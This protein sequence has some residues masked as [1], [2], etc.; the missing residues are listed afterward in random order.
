MKG[1][2]EQYTEEM[3][4]NFGYYA[5]WE[6]GR[7]L[8][9][10]DIGTIKNNVFTRLSDLGSKGIA[11]E[12]NPDETAND[13]EYNSKG[14]VSVTTKLS[15]TVA[16]VGSSLTNVDAGIIVEFSKENSTLFKANK[17]RTPSIKDITALGAEILKRY[18]EGK[19]NKYWVIITE[20]V[21]AESATIIISATANS[22]LELKATANVDA[23]DVDIANANFAF[24][25]I[26]S[27]G[28]DTKIIAEA[29]L[30]PL[31]KLM[32]IKD[33]IFIKPSFTN[34][35][36]RAFDFVTPETA[37]GEFKDKLFFGYI[38]EPDNR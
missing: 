13:L 34:K 9:L 26:A 30:T 33:N 7:P 32:G 17:T 22:K 18:R 10:G 5:T 16:P 29:G 1:P 28:I 19:W 36:I 12:T 23:Q 27:A 21:I 37:K 2:Q 14:S 25:R 6:P 8:A 20:L 4:E 35:G 15:G 11:F 38:D 24:G 3:K 31:F